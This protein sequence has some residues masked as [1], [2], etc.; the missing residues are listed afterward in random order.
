MKV[1]IPTKKHTGL[2]DRVSEVF[3]RAETFTIVDV[4]DEKIENT[5][6]ID[7]PAASYEYGSGPVAVKSLADRGVEWVLAGRLGPGA[8]NILEHHNI[9]H[10]KVTPNK[11]VSDILQE[12]LPKL[13]TYQE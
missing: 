2:D 10:F 7:N 13:K 11:K 4:K 5:D 9:G 3:G 12:A 8:S 6:V 1:A